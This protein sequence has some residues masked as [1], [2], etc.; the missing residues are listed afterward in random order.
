MTSTRGR[1][2]V[3]RL[4]WTL[5]G[6]ALV[7]VV[8]WRVGSW[9]PAADG[10]EGGGP[11]GGQGSSVLNTASGLDL[12]P[13]G[14]RVPAPNLRGTTLDGKP[15]ALSD[16]AGTI[17]VIN[18]WGSWCAPCRA[19]APD[20]V[21]LANQTTDLGVRFVGVNTRDNPA[22]AQA[23]VR[24]FAVPYPSIRDDNGQVLLAYRALIPTSAVPTTVVV[25]RDGKVAARVLGRVTYRTLQGILDDEV[26][27]SKGRR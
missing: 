6:L 2:A 9:S 14:Q 17:V 10:S 3:R 20:L 23:F 24:S 18:V 26:A 5:A 15:W 21:R 11:A 25:D 4:G 27:A 8:A 1:R 13:A 19:E 7:A 22:A 16:R 12:Y